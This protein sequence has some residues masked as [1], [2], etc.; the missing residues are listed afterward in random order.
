M[1]DNNAI[2]VTSIDDY[3]KEQLYDLAFFERVTHHY[4]WNWLRG[5]IVD[6]EQYGVT[7]FVFVH[8][9]I[10]DFKVVNEIYGHSVGDN[11]LAKVCKVM[12]ECDWVY[13]SCRCDNDNFAM[14]IHRMPDD[15]VYEKLMEMFGK[16]SFLDEDAGFPIF[17]RCGVASIENVRDYGATVTDMAKM[18]QREGVKANITEVRF[19][20]DAMKEE[21]LRSKFLKSE[22][23]RAFRENELMVY[24]QP[25]CDPANNELMGAEA[26]IRWNYKHD[27]LLMPGEFVPYFEQEGT[28]EK[29]DRFVLEQVC[30]N[31]E[32]WKKKGM[33]LIPI[34][35]N[36]SRAQL[37]NPLMIKHILAIVDKYDVDRSLIE[38]ELTESLAYGDAEYLIRVMKQLRELGFGLSIDDFG[39]GYSSLSLLSSMP[40]TTLKIDKSFVDKLDHNE[41]GITD[42]IVQHILGLSKH[43]CVNSVAEGVETQYQKELLEKWGCDYIQGY[44]YYK[45]IPTDQFEK[46]MSR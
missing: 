42:Y 9:D 5:R 32:A 6:C 13:C 26:L 22:L 35:V 44:Y 11:L 2:Q 8:F 24:L 16:M 3:T 41:E 18:A 33:K 46:L 10:K 12:R 30:I 25:K 1:A 20:T 28:I 7:D 31:L 38:F 45:P 23:P 21:T 15:K 29:I 39:T 34:S 19:Y 40:L 37:Y 43:L 4:N 27:K 14:M 17:F 36:M